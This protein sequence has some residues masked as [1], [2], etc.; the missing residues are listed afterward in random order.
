M[1]Q[2]LSPPKGAENAKEWLA[3]CRGLES[4]R[5]LRNEE[6]RELACSRNQLFMIKNIA[7]RTL[8]FAC[9][10]SAEY[11]NNHTQALN[12]ASFHRVREAASSRLMRMHAFGY[13]HWMHAFGY[14]F[15][16]IGYPPTGGGLGSGSAGLLTY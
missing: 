4:K 3:I 14:I 8:C 7:L 9:L 5:P 15:V 11:C 10:R 13:I 2:M 6:V 12:C 16:A 1:G